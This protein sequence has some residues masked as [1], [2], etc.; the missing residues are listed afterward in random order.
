MFRRAIDANIII[1]NAQLEAQEKLR[2]KEAPC[3][4]PKMDIRADKKRTIQYTDAVHE[5][6]SRREFAA[7]HFEANNPPKGLKVV[8]DNGGETFFN[9]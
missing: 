9:F 4:K 5:S 7:P 2:N 8:K 3:K 1:P 6:V